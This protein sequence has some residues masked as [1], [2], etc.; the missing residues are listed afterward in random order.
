MLRLI[1]HAEDVLRLSALCSQCKDGTKAI[2]SKRV[3][4]DSMNGV[5]HVGSSESYQPVCR[6]HYLEAK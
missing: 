4:S 3:V 6:K 5:I 2:Y 1:P